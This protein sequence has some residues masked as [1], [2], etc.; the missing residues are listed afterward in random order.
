M[1]LP[2]RAALG[3]MHGKAAALGPPRLAY[4]EITLIRPA[5][6]T[7]RFGTFTA[8]TPPDGTI[9]DAARAKARAAIA[10]TG[11]PVCIGSMGSCGPRP[12]IPVLP[13]GRG[14]LLWH[15]VE[16]GREFIE[17]A[18]DERPRTDN[19]KVANLAKAKAL[20]DRIDVPLTALIVAPAS[21]AMPIAMGLR[22]RNGL[23]A[24]IR[25]AMAT[26]FDGRTFWQTD[27]ARI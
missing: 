12:S 5:T 26:S 2:A 11:L 19:A 16:T 24:A 20:L 18:F 6:D 22:D 3:T 25:P 14:M 7:D 17:Q 13:R 15:K 10:A 4:V 21:A 1:T 9:A 23:M 27:M 8:K